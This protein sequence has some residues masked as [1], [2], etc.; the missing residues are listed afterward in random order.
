MFS[1]GTRKCVDMFVTGSSQVWSVPTVS[2]IFDT[3]FTPLISH[4][5]L[6]VDFGVFY[7]NQALPFGGAKSS[8]YGR[9]A[10]REGLIG[11]CNPKAITED[12]FHGLI[13]TGIPPLL[14]YPINSGKGAWT[15]VSGLVGMI[16]GNTGERVRGVWGLISA[17]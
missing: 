4:A 1:V 16:Y 14:A 10:G 6:C 11:L 12:R 7:L 2:S 15:F 17:K 5:A 13:Q 3:F 9:F 8:G